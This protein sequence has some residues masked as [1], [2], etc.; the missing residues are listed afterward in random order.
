M[1]ADINKQFYYTNSSFA[2]VKEFLFIIFSL[3]LFTFQFGCD[4][5]SRSNPELTYTVKRGDFS[6]TLKGTGI[7]EAKNSINI[8]AP[9]FRDNYKITYMIP[10]GSKVKK[11]DVVATFKSNLLENEYKNVKNEL[12]IAIAEREQKDEQLKAEMSKLESQLKSYEASLSTAKLRLVKIEFVAPKKQEIEKLEIEKAELQAEKLKRKLASL[13]NVHK[14]ERRYMEMKVKQ[15]ENKFKRSQLLMD[16]LIQKAPVDGIV[17]YWVFWWSGTKIK[18]GDNR[19]WGDPIMEIPDI[20]IMQVNMKVG[21]TEAQKIKSGQKAVVTVSSTGDFR[22]SGKVSRIDKIAK[23]IKIKDGLRYKDSKIKKVGVFVEIDSNSVN[24]TPGLTAE[25]SI[26][27][28]EFKD[29]LAVPHECIFEKDSVKV[30]YVREGKQYDLRPVELD[31]Q[32]EDFI[33]VKNGLNSGEKLALA[34]PPSSLII[35]PDSI[36]EKRQ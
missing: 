11:G 17:S 35:I 24:L 33:F 13:K 6:I 30:V 36:K 34:K 19:L 5:S 14:E 18:V 32:D 29:V 15:A 21:E 26:V 1:G 25:C 12:D 20:S 9:Q 4:S 27:I 3:L 7:L 8:N 16:Q 22:L 10:E 2:I 23:A 31:Y 28:E